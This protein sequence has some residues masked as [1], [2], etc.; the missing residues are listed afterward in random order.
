MK[1]YTADA[2]QTDSCIS[3]YTDLLGK[4]LVA[5]KKKRRGKLTQVPLLLHDSAS[6]IS[7][8]TCWTSRCMWIWRN[9][10]STIFSWTDTKWLPSP[11]LSLAL[12]HWMKEEK[13]WRRIFSRD[14]FSPAAPYCTAYSLIE[15]TMTLLAACEIRNPFTQSKHVLINSVNRLYLTVS[16]STHS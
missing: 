9:V 10:P 8:V 6:T 4:L 16:T 1:V 11:W 14:M 5:V 12:T 7:Q 15:E 13:C 2:S 3:L